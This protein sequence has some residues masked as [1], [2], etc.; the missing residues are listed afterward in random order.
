VSFANVARGIEVLCSGAGRFLA[1]QALRRATNLF[2]GAAHT[3]ALP[4][5]S[6]PRKISDASCKSG[7]FSV[8]YKS[9]D[10]KFIRP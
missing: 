10:G 6:R 4:A 5:A 1:A 2:R 9:A 3:L 7:V 8:A